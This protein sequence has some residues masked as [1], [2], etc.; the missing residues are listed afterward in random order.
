MFTGVLTGTDK[1]TASLSLPDGVPTGEVSVG[2]HDGDT[3]Y[4][5]VSTGAV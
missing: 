3:A 4:N 1:F 5:G 2:A